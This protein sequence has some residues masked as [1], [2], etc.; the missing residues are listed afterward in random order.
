MPGNTAAQAAFSRARRQLR[1]IPFLNTLKAR[2]RGQFTG[3]PLVLV[4]RIHM[5]LWLPIAPDEA[6]QNQPI[7]THAILWYRFAR[8]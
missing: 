7:K 3:N 8:G 1:T 4:F 5:W 2:P 6:R